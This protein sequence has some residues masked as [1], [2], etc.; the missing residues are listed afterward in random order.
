[1]KKIFYTVAITCALFASNTAFSQGTK[2]AGQ[3]AATNEGDLIL[4]I[5]IGFGGG[6]YS[7]S[8]FNN[9]GYTSNSGGIPTLSVSLQKAFWEDITIG[10]EIAFNTYNDES[11]NFNGSGTKASY[12]K[13]SQTN[14][15]L[16]GKG[17]YHFNRL[18]GLDPKFDLYAGA[19]VGLRFSG[20]KNEYTDYNNN[21]NT[22]YKNN[23]VNLEAGAFGG[24]RY[25]FVPGMAVYAEVGWA[26]TP[27]RTGL[28]WKF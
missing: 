5:G 17:E 6:Y 24:F 12:N 26:I 25:Y 19:I 22:S 27:F 23:Y 16:L 2:N 21:T 4:D 18:I 3:D 13:Y 9:Y 20:A 14:T 1:M 28:A 8:S 10:G 15:F 11:T 7:Q